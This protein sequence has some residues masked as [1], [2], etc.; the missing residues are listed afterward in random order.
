MNRRHQ[1]YIRRMS[2]AAKEF[3]TDRRMNRRYMHSSSDTLGFGNSKGQSLASS[4]PDDPTLWPAVYP[5][6]TFKSYRDTPKLLLQHRMNQRFRNQQAVHLTPMFKLH[7]TAQSECSSTLD[8]PTGHRCIDWVTW[9]NG[10]FSDCEWPD[11]STPAQGGTIGSSDGTTFQGN[12]S[13]G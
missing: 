8:G 11:N 3:K 13:N 12:F 4:A 5:T 2:S 1:I 6:L 7:S 9:F 10:Y